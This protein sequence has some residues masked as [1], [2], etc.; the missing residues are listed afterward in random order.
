MHPF[1]PPLDSLQAY[2]AGDPRTWAG[3]P[4]RLWEEMR[5]GEIVTVSPS[6]LMDGLTAATE[7]ATVEIPHFIRGSLETTAKSVATAH[8][9]GHHTL[10]HYHSRW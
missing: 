1:C 5:F 10:S 4:C 7:N 8:A 3:V 2:S 6:F 9:L